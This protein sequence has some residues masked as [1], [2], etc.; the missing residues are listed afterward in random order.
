MSKLSLDQ[1]TKTIAMIAIFAALYAALRIIPT[2]PMVGTGAT[3]RVSDILAPL[4]GIVLGPFIGGAAI[5]IGTFAAI[6]II[7]SAPFLGLDFLP[8]FI[9]AVSLGLLVKGKWLPTVVLNALLLVVYAVNPLT[10][11][12]I[13]TP[14][15]IIPYLWMHIAAFI[16]LLSPLGRNAGKWVKS[17]KTS[18][19][20][21]GFIILAF[22]GT[23]MQ[24]LMG[25]ILYE[26][27]LGQLTGTIKPEAF[28]GIWN[29]VFYV[30]PWERLA[31]IIGAVVVGVPVTRAL[32]KFIF[33]QETKPVTNTNTAQA[34]L[35]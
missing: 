26:T 29:V 27:I 34:T 23:M 2:V 12:F 5:L 4:Y 32:K 11:N 28:V 35:H 14:L 10:V 3:F 8:A 17:S 18:T 1:R 13:V 25:N 31:L 7:P 21:A 16:V 9:V 6:G 30:Y 33:P 15:G 22:V 19:I 20:T 24:H